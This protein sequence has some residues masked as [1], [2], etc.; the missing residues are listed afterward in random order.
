MIRDPLPPFTP[1]IRTSVPNRINIEDSCGRIR[2]M[3]RTKLPGI[4]TKSRNWDENPARSARNILSGRTADVPLPLLK[5]ARNEEKTRMWKTKFNALARIF[6]TCSSRGAAKARLARRPKPLRA[7]LYGNILS[8]EECE[9]KTPRRRE[10]LDRAKQGGR[11]PPP[12]VSFA[13]S[14]GDAFGLKRPTARVSVW[15]AFSRLSALDD[16][17][18]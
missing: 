4:R 16:C 1:W 6:H 2:T 9:E 13:L 15:R 17:H 5:S 18:L 7:G 10:S 11:L 8:G 14:A 3:I 12:L